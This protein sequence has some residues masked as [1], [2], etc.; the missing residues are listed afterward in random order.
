MKGEGKETV[1]PLMKQYNAIKAKHP[2]ALLLF[3]VGDFYETF[4]EDAVKASKLLDIVLTKRGAGSPS[5]IALA[6]FPHHSLD[7]YL[8][9]L[10]RAGERVA[11]CDQLEDPKSVKGIVKRG[12]TE[13]V[14]PG[15]SFNDQVLERRSNNYLA[16]VQFGKTEVGISFLD[17]STGEFITAQGDKNYIGKL[18]QSLAPAEVLF[19]KRE[20]ERFMELYGPDFRYYALEEWV[21]SHDFAYESLTR[22]FGTATLKGFGIEGMA[23]GI[24]SAGAI[25]H[26]LSETQHN[27][28]S[29]V[30]TISR[31]E[32]DKY[33]WLDRFTVRNLEL[34]YPQHPEGVPLIEV[35][36]QTITPMGARLLKKWVVLPLK[37]VV[38]I[39][40]RLDTVEALMQHDE[41]LDELYKHLKQIN[42]LERLISKVAVRRVNPRELVQLAKA[43]EAILPIKKILAAS[44]I[45]ALQKLA[46]QLAPCDGLRE[47]IRNTLKAE[48]PMLTNQGNMVNDGVHEELDELRAISFSGKDY[49]AQ[50]QQ[51][52]VKNTG[53]SSLKIA[54]NKVFGYYLEVSNAHKDKVPAS[55]IRK[56]TLVN[57]ER[58][59]T[60]E[61]KTYEEKILNAEERIYAIEFG[62]FNELVLHALDYV[63]QIQQNAKVIGV[64]DCLSSFANIAQS[65]NYVKPEVSDSLILDITKGRHPVIEKQLPLGEVY[66]PNDIFLDKEEQ[67]IVIITGPNMA[68]KSALLRQTALIVLMAQIGSFVPAEAA[69]IGVID[70]IFTRVGASDN[71]SKGESTFMVEMT[72]T[73]SILN[74]LSDRSLILMDEIGRGTSTYDG[75]SIAWAI[76][77]HLHNH[78][79]FRGKTLFATHYH[80]LNQ[81]AEDLPRVKNYNVSVKEAGGKI[82]F[83]RKLVAGGSEHSFGI[84]VAQMA[85]MPNNVVLRANEIMHHLEKEKVTDEA[86]QQKLKHAPKSNYQLSMFELNDPQLARVKELMEQL[87]INTITPVE[88][89]LKLNEL[90]LLLQD[91]KREAVR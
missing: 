91:K 90:K 31:L 69:K 64:I 43:L 71:L 47:E 88:A 89:L 83:M 32:E 2:G 78:P 77:E 27:E 1:T 54:Y 26:Y 74:N 17:I 50:V 51:R 13:L 75:I 79:Q 55:W 14:T 65:S 42:D 10:V 12:V 21:F 25:L 29:H 80:E 19:C 73:A 61:L 81:L 18:L 15:V 59:I 52:E 53:I 20:K 82:L 84:H 85:G 63:A 49:L 7:T 62:L 70:K 39:R 86:P 41:L 8:P 16:A 22:Q 66:V 33:V 46:D 72:E 57:A 11:I 38:Q 28:I 4:G 44:G 76:V 36:D 48:P 30:A 40:R 3:R 6:G 23:E 87:D 56:Q 60:E 24:I 68:G 58:Y 9:K 34:L 35:L 45:P 5:E 37:D 67:Q